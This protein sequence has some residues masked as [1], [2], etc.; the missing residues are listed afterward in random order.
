MILTLIGYWM[1]I[2]CS[3][4]YLHIL[5]INTNFVWFFSDC[6]KTTSSPKKATIFQLFLM[7][8]PNDFL[9]PSCHNYESLPT[10]TY[11][12][13]VVFIYFLSSVMDLLLSSN[14]LWSLC[15]CHGR[16]FL[17]IFWHKIYEP[18]SVIKIRKVFT[19][20]CNLERSIFTNLTFH[21][22]HWS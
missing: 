2:G 22:G 13:W 18:E 14:A 5:N 6:R 21:I 17:N 11:Q 4:L 10:Y 12:W 1:S 16:K 9:L 19:K 20:I 15:F 7:D 3:M 8:D